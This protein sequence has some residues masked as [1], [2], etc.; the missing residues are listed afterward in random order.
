MVVAVTVLAALQD[1]LSFRIANAFPLIVAGLF[2]VT[3][4][5][6]AWPPAALGWSVGLALAVF[7]VGAG[8]FF[9]GVWGGGDVKI[10]AALTLWVH[11]GALLPFLAW[12]MIA[13]GVLG[14]LLLLGRFLPKNVKESHAIVRRWFVVEAGNRQSIPYGLAIM[15]G[16]LMMWVQGTLGPPTGAG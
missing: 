5:T 6:G 4:L 13:G 12:V 1:M 8:L 11:P 9:A 2:I 14:L 10:L 7:G 16:T 3:A 15:I